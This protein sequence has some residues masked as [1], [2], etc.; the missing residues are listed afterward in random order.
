[1][2]IIYAIGLILCFLIQPQIEIVSEDT[3]AFRTY[4]FRTVC[5]LTVATH[6]PVLVAGVYLRKYQWGNLTSYYN[7]ATGTFLK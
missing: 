5:Y 3:S 7:L 1:M 2:I 4:L 6:W